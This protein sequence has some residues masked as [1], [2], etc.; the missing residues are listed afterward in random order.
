MRWIIIEPNVGGHRL[1]YYNHLYQKAIEMLEDEFLFVFTNDYNNIRN[2]F[3]WK[4]SNNIT[5]KVLSK[6]ESLRIKSHHTLHSSLWR[7]AILFKEIYNFRPDKVLLLEFQFY[8]PFLWILAIAFKHVTF[9]GI[10]FKSYPYRWKECST[11]TRFADMIKL[12]IL[13]NG[14]HISKIF[15]INDRSSVCYLNKLYKTERFVFA[16]DPIIPIKRHNEFDFRERFAIGR[17]KI[18]L[19]QF[20][21]LNSS[22]GTLNFI[23]AL[24]MLDVEDRSK[25]ACVLAGKASVEIESQLRNEVIELSQTMQIVFI[26]RFCSYDM[27]SSLC[28]ASNYIVLA[29]KK[30]EGSSGCLGIASQFHT[31]VISTSKNMLG[32]LI[33]RNKLGMTL[34]DVS[35]VGLSE[36]IKSIIRNDTPPSNWGFDTYIQCNSVENFNSILLD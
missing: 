23:N 22:K 5:I 6:S 19:S 12:Y 25:I 32:K 18:L 13:A 31:P 7:C 30:N 17:D 34:G 15:I 11:L 1:E 14:K 28:K 4:E 10:L 24:K 27:I 26:N 2:R 29:Y 3:D 21:S 20:G 16:P 9:S 35:A 36:A 33:K 8:L